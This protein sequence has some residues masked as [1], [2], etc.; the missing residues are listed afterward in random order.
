MAVA[1]AIHSCMSAE[2]HSQAFENRINQRID[3]LEHLHQ[4]LAKHI[5]HIDSGNVQSR[6]L[7]L[8]RYRMGLSDL[9][10]ESQY[11]YIPEQDS[12]TWASELHLYHQYHQLTYGLLL[13]LML[14]PKID[15]LD[16]IRMFE[17]KLHER[18]NLMAGKKELFQFQHLLP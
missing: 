3:S 15:Q 5:L 12:V 4:S 13:R 8:L 17:D 1:L 14:N 2:D 11:D 7:Q 9:I 16:S 18:I 6:H 10:L